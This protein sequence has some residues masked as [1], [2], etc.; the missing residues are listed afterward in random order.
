VD[1]LRGPAIAAE[2][3][4][5]TERSRG[6][7]IRERLEAAIF[8][9]A[10]PVLRELV[11]ATER[12]VSDGNSA[13][14]RSTEVVRSKATVV[15]R[16]VLGPVLQHVTEPATTPL[17]RGATVEALQAL[18]QTLRTEADPDPEKTAAKFLAAIPPHVAAEIRTRLATAV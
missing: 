13:L 15:Q 9:R 2:E 4:V 10:D 8:E 12:L 14:W 3:A 1:A 6:P 5:C 11:A 16:G 7:E 18:K 17:P